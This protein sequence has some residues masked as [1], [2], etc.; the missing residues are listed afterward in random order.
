MAIEEDSRLLAVFYP[1]PD[2]LLLWFS[3]FMAVSVSARLLCSCVMWLMTETPGVLPELSGLLV[4]GR[5]FRP[6][7]SEPLM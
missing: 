4:G 5:V 7:P 1:M 3:S 6:C 2:K